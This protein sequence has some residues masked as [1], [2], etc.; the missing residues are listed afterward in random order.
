MGRKYISWIDGMLSH[1]DGVRKKSI[2]YLKILLLAIQKKA[3]ISNRNRWQRYFIL[4]KVLPAPAHNNYY[5][6]EGKKALSL[7]LSSPDRPTYYIYIYY[8]FMNASHENE[9]QSTIY[10]QQWCQTLCLWSKWWSFVCIWSV[11]F[12][13]KIAARSKKKIENAKKKAHSKCP[14][15]S[16]NC[17]TI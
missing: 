15:A 5:S 8:M 13:K 12:G 2:F 6:P 7:W 16:H 4:L 3:T 17:N 14:C 1:H 10:I 9:L 11:I